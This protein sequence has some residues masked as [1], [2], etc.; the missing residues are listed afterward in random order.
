LRFAIN[1]VLADCRMFE[2]SFEGVSG[3]LLNGL[4]VS[5]GVDGLDEG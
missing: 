2:S 4:G 3:I 5:G 1:A